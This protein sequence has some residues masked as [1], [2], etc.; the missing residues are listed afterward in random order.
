MSK[1]ICFIQERKE[2]SEKNIAEYYSKKERAEWKE[3]YR[4]FIKK[5][6]RQERRILQNINKERKEL[7]KES[8]AKY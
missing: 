3:Y 7:S 2:L 8:I 4:I 5:G 1:L 6:K